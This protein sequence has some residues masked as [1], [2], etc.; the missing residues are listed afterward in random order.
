MQCAPRRGMIAHIIFKAKN[1]VRPYAFHLQKWV[2]IICV[3]S[4]AHL[5]L[6]SYSKQTKIVKCNN[7]LTK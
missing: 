6:Q 7:N 4:N 2:Q 3:S 5:I 1:N